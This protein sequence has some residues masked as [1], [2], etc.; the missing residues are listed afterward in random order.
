LIG[1]QKIN[2][3]WID[4]K[5]LLYKLEERTQLSQQVLLNL[6]LECKIYSTLNWT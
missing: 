2:T 3:S 1:F 4:L 5:I 6:D